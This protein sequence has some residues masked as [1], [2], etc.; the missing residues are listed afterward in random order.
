[1]RILI[2][3]PAGDLTLRMPLL[4]SG[5]C[6]VTDERGTQCGAGVCGAIVEL[7]ISISAL[8]VAPR[9]QIGMLVRLMRDE[10]E[11]DRLPRYGELTLMVPDEGFERAH[12]HV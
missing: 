4:P 12:W 5:E 2:A 1:M 9:D 10:V 8:G 3:R 7:S 11:V 6:P